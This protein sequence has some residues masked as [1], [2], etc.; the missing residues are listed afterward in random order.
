MLVDVL[1][2]LGAIF[3]K[4]QSFYRSVDIRS[5]NNEFQSNLFGEYFIAAF[6]KEIG[7]I[8]GSENEDFLLT[9]FT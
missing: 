8:G 9:L 5:D 1:M 7:V 4:G 3:I 6:S 2:T